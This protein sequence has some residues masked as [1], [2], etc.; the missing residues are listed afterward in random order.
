MGTVLFGYMA[1]TC[2]RKIGLII[3][4]VPQIAANIL[5]LIGSHYY[6]VYAARFLFGLTAGGVFIMIPIFVSEISHDK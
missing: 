1:D 4:A 6:Y 3:I 5:L 2:G